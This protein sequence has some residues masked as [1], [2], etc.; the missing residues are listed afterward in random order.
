MSHEIRTPLNAVMGL[1]NLLLTS[2]LTAEQRDFI[3]TIQ[4]SGDN[5]LSIVNDILDF[6]KVEAG[7]LDLE[8]RRFDLFAA[9]ESARNLVSDEAMPKGLTVEARFAEG[10]PQFVVGDVTRLRQVLVNLLN[11]AVKF[12]DVGSVGVE[13]RAAGAH[14]LSFEIRD[15]GIGIPADRLK[16]LFEAFI[17]VDPSTTRRFGGTG[18]G[19]AISAR[20][21]KLMGGIMEV[22]SEL[23]RGS[24]FRFTVKAQADRNQRPQE[25]AAHFEIDPNRCTRKPHRILVAE[26]NIINQ[27]V[28]LNMLD[29]LGYRADVAANGR[30]VIE[31]I[32]RQRYDVVLMDVQMP[33]MGGV[34]AT[35]LIRSRD[36][37][38]S[39][40]WIIAV[41][42]NALKGDREMFL[43]A[44][45]D[46]YLS[47]PLMMDPLIAALRAVPVD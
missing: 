47:K 4:E 18:L 6:S 32:E 45:M 27:K 16:D 20:L 1:N 22:E 39:Q 30:E 36:L 26:D 11:N 9:V 24:V 10:L 13:V 42:A 17:Q 31:A 46:D 41:T 25:S 2:E 5:L 7:K 23:G 15:S 37:S 34:E 14:M 29:Y 8:H 35:Q 43:G 21:V 33:E 19:L 40:P 44:G 38:Q 28:V 3:T 12:T